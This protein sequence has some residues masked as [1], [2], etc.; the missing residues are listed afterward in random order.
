MSA[1]MV[2]YNVSGVRVDSKIN[3]RAE[4][5]YNSESKLSYHEEFWM[6]EYKG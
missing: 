4:A 1:A 2:F 3:A 5:I 6:P